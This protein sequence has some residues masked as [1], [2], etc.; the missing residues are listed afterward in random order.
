MAAT[1]AGGLHGEED[2][3]AKVVSEWNGKRLG[4]LFVCGFSAITCITCAVVEET[5]S[6]VLAFALGILAFY[7]LQYGNTSSSP[8]DD[9]ELAAK[10]E[11]VDLDQFLQDPESRTASKILVHSL[12]K[13]HLRVVGKLQKYEAG[14]NA[15]AIPSPTGSEEQDRGAA[16]RIESVAIDMIE[17]GDP[18]A[19]SEVS[20]AM[21]EAQASRKASLDSEVSRK[22]SSEL[23]E[24][25]IARPEDEEDD[26]KK[27]K[28]AKKE[29]KERSGSMEK[30]KKEK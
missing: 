3:P 19:E 28:K 11:G 7:T 16:A 18:V 21:M 8:Q 22:N 20:G 17:E 29:K 26:E 2:V 23:D 30:T 25:P 9:V 12:I 24:V 13:E 27:V 15:N 1:F 6:A 14:A 4:L 10:K 5:L